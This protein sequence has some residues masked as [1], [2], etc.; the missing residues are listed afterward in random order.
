MKF[1]D[2][3][4]WLYIILEVDWQEVEVNYSGVWYNPQVRILS[5]ET[6]DQSSHL[7]ANIL[8]DVSQYP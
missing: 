2:V 7:S 5:C 4:V 6:V 8:G 3:E 1:W